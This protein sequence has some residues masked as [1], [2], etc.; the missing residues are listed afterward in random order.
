MTFDNAVTGPPGQLRQRPEV[1]LGVVAGLLRN[2]HGRTVRRPRAGGAEHVD[3]LRESRLLNIN[4]RLRHQP[5][6]VKPKI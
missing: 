4:R 2:L 1:P 5:Q 3:N 6:K